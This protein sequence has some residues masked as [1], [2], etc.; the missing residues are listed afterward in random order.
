MRIIAQKGFV[1]L[2]SVILSLTAAAKLVSTTGHA[3]ILDY[4]DPLLAISNRSVLTGVAVIELAVVACLMS[5]LPQPIKYLA[6]A[7]LGGNFLLYRLAL[8]VLK[9]GTPCKCLGTITEQLHIDDRAAGLILSLISLYL[10]TGG[11]WL[12]VGARKTSL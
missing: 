1:V 12:Y 6:A 8:A 10:L 9:P 4:P 11:F 2:S 5:K 7:W 3:R